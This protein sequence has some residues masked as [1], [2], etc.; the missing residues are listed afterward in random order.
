MWVK[1]KD[2]AKLVAAGIRGIVIFFTIMAV[3]DQVWIATEVTTTILNWFIAM[4]AI[5]WGIAF[6]LWGKD[7]ARDILES[8]RK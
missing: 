2:T 3:L 6:W 8:F 4:L 1:S 5:A 7:V